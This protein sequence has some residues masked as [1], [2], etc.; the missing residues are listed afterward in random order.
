[1]DFIGSLGVR[2]SSSAAED[3]DINKAAEKV[4]QMI[5]EKHKSP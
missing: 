2:S 1:M 4:E 5:I 3:R